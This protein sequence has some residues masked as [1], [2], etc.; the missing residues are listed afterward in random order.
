MKCLLLCMWTWV[1]LVL[2]GGGSMGCLEE[3]KN[4]LLKIKAAFNHPNGSS[5]PS[6]RDGNGD[7]CGW[8]GVECDNTTL[9]VTQLHLGGKRD[10]ELRESGPWVIH[11]SLF[12][13]LV[14]LQELD[15]S[16]NSLS[17][18]NGTLHLKKL[19]KL[20]LSFNQLERIPSL[21]KQTSTE[22]QIL[23]SNQLEG[24]NLELL[25]LFGNNLINDA[26]ED[27]TRITSLKVLDVSF[28]GLNAA[29]LLEG[30]YVK[31]LSF[32]IFLKLRYGKIFWNIES[33][34]ALYST[35]PRDQFWL[36]IFFK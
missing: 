23:S 14:E 29:K 30:T 8:E 25:D 17:E 34:T 7:C 16:T 1:L 33:M 32:I 28:C 19:K 26:F 18:L 20:F 9:R 24:M 5:L 13:P 10:W 27:I 22:A 3:E 2:M 15:L 36:H 12:I 31:M 35:T 4:A 6:W 21:Y 11:A